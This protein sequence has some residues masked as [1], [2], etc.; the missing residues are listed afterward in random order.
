[1]T[2]EPLVIYRGKNTKILLDGNAVHNFGP[3]SENMFDEVE[4]GII[5]HL[6]YASPVL[7]H[8]N[9]KK[10]KSII[11]DENATVVTKMKI[12]K[13]KMLPFSIG[14][15]VPTVDVMLYGKPHTTFTD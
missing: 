6:L 14:A 4:G 5:L 3:V 9:P 13:F 12:E 2:D 10:F 7:K 11:C 15:S 1:M 8:F